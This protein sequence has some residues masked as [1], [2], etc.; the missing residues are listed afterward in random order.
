VAATRTAAGDVHVFWASGG[1]TSSLVY[2][3][4]PG[5]P[6]GFTWA[7]R[8]DLPVFNVEAVANGNTTFVYYED[9]IAGDVKAMTFNGTTFSSPVQALPVGSIPKV[10]VDA[11]GV[12]RLTAADASAYPVVNVV[13]ASSANG[14]T[15]GP[16]AVAIT[17]DGTVTNWDPTLAQT[18]DGAY[19]LFHAPDLG[20]GSQRIDHRSSPTFE[21]LAAAVGTPVTTPA[22]YWDYW[23]E[24]LTIN[25]VLRLFYTSEAGST[26]G[27]GHIWSSGSQV[28]P[29]S[30]DDCKNGGWAAFGYRNQGQCVSAVARAK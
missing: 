25:G 5:G 4:D 28:T 29:S 8:A 3:V 10:I 30:K 24:A 22:G 23:P 1:N 19:H 11:T 2:G 9:G 20:T 12:F 16:A 18:P 27:T 7:S 14:L 6:G 15:F 13:L 21:G 26:P 17:G